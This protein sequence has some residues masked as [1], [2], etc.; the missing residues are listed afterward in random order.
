MVSW[1]MALSKLFNLFVPQLSIQNMEKVQ[2]VTVRTRE[3][4]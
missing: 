1:L 3:N 2:H 4:T